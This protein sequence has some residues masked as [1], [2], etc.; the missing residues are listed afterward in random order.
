[1]KNFTS[2]LFKRI[3]PIL[4]IVFFT[5][6]TTA[7]DNGFVRE[8]Y[9]P[10]EPSCILYERDYTGPSSVFRSQEVIDKIARGTACSDIFVAYTGFTPEAQA[11]F[12]FAVEIW[13]NTLESP[14]A[15]R[16]DANFTALGAGV[17]G[18]AG[19]TNFLTS[20]AP[21]TLPNTFYPVA[22]WEKLNNRDSDSG[23]FGPDT[24]TSTD[25]S[26]NFSSSFNF[27][28]GTDAN[29]PA[30]QFDFVSIV[31]HE[32]G[33]GLGFT[34]LRS[35]DGTTGSI[36]VTA[37]ANPTIYDVFVENGTG[38]SILSFPD[39]STDLHD[40]FVGGDLFCNG[41]Q[42]TAA[43]SGTLNQIYAPSTYSGGS[44]YAHWNEATY[45]AGDVNSLM[46]PQIGPGEAN[47]NPGPITL[48]FF[49]DMGWSLC[50]TLSVDD[51]ELDNIE[52]SPNPFT[53]TLTINLSNSLSGDYNINLFDINGRIVRT[54]ATSSVNGSIRI[55]NLDN[56]QNALYFVKITNTTN[57][58]SITKKVIK[59]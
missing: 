41:P 14:K 8:V 49:E 35:S 19:P 3:L 59:N 40:E 21:G 34:S 45:V 25:I 12:Q 52:I 15:I 16:I 47:H 6:L 13:K 48:G 30:G 43:N 32:L 22:L 42:S 56:L 28:F 55:S 7:Q 20:S 44:S 50:A 54:E 11:A 29:P 4:G 18:S 17:L 10:T 36:R 23:M 1:M 46:T 38:A 37:A 26:C 39:P 53:S 2:K 24:G 9:T 51:F 57:G 5:Q 58:Q 33:H 31:L 27:Y